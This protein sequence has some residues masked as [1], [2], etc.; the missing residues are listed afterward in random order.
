MK[1]VQRQKV[2]NPNFH[3]RDSAK[4]GDLESVRLAL[5]SGAD[6][7]SKQPILTGLFKFNISDN[8]CTALHIAARHGHLD[9]VKY[10]IQEGARIDIETIDHYTPLD[11]AVEYKQEEVV[12]YLSNLV[13]QINQFVQNTVVNQV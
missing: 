9:I 11:I 10:L 5:E 13:N 3:L 12:T 2:S 8:T 7:N 1:A 4:K 6:I